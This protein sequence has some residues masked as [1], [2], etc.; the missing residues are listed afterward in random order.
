LQA[1]QPQLVAS[2]VLPEVLRMAVLLQRPRL[3]QHMWEFG[4]KLGRRGAADVHQMQFVSMA[5]CA[6]LCGYPAA[7]Q[8]VLDLPG[9]KVQVWQQL[10]AL[11]LLARQR[12]AVLM[13]AGECFRQQQLM[14]PWMP[15][16]MGLAFTVGKAGYPGALQGGKGAVGSSAA[17]A[18]DTSQ[19]QP[20]TQQGQT[21]QLL[22]EQQEQEAFS[23]LQCMQQVGSLIAAATSSSMTG[24]SSSTGSSSCWDAAADSHCTWLLLRYACSSCCVRHMTHM[25]CRCCTQPWRAWML[26]QRLLLQVQ[27]QQGLQQLVQQQVQPQRSM[28]QMWLQAQQELRR[29]QRVQPQQS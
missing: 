24:G 26:Q 3:L 1:K 21:P 9:R 2:Q 18:A 4:V 13:L 27:V 10:L 22:L 19:Q 12:E 5:V 8:R 29:Q 16:V 15:A 7:F 25:H 6:V 20:A 28:R 14:Q 11:A 17:A 23:Q